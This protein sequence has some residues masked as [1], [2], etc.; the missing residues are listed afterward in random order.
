M[1]QS[2]LYC[3]YGI[4]QLG[5]YPGFDPQHIDTTG[6]NI[7]DISAPPL[8]LIQSISSLYMIFIVSNFNNP[9]EIV[10]AQELIKICRN[11]SIFIS[12]ITESKN[13]KREDLL[14][15]KNEVDVFLTLD[16]EPFLDD[17]HFDSV[18]YAIRFL[19]DAFDEELYEFEDNPFYDG[20][21]YAFSKSG[22]AKLFTFELHKA[23]YNQRQLQLMDSVVAKISGKRL[24]FV[25]FKSGED[26][27]SWP[28]AYITNVIK[29]TAGSML[30][31]TC[32]G[33][34]SDSFGKRTFITVLLSDLDNPNNSYGNGKDKTIFQKRIR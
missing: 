32:H 31:A 6:K 7:I 28:C 9:N 26:S 13:A 20:S 30:Y 2:L 21:V 22:Q 11:H 25:Y 33:R 29:A 4:C 5:Q 19:A 24:A 10:Y 27:R 17:S 34:F 23:D 14:V 18:A 3:E 8:E 1:R 12:A 15:L 16:A